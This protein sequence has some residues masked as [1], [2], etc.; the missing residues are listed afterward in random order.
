MK[1]KAIKAAKKFVNRVS[2]SGIPV[3]KAFLFGSHAR[4]TAKDYSDIDICV[5]SPKFGKNS[6]KEMSLL[7]KL[8]VGLDSRIEPFPF[9]EKGLNDRYS[10]L[11]SEIR[12]Y[13][14]LI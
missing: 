7:L 1:N 4:G 14:I 6:F 10:T 5:V 13:G 9:N 11:A 12:K 3:T 2:G 8:S